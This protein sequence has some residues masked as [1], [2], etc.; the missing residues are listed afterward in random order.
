MIDSHATAARWSVSRTILLA[1]LAA[2]IVEML[3]V[4]PVQGLLGLSPLALFQ[5]IASGWQVN[6]AY[7]G[8]IAGAL[9]GA[10]LHL[11]FSIIA[12]GIFVYASRIWP[13]LLQ[14]YISAGLI[15]GA[16]VYAVMTYAAVPLSA[17]RFGPVTDGS[18][19]AAS[20]AVHLCFFGLP[21]S[22]VTRFSSLRPRFS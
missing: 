3:V 12:A 9:F 22:L 20:F 15:Y 7:A 14:R 13:V 21:I 11:S 17:L 18:L 2:A 5:S 1:G 8:G 4:I 16:L 10:A 19:I 6:A